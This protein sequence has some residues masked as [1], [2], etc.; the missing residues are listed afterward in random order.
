MYKLYI[1]H[2][3]SVKQYVLINIQVLIFIKIFF[4]IVLP[5]EDNKPIDVSRILM[6]IGQI[7]DVKKHPDAD[8]LYVEQGI[9]DNFCLER[10]FMNQMS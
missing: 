2:L 4:S 6:K 1:V 5:V 10:L 3:C 8:S 9:V 7:I